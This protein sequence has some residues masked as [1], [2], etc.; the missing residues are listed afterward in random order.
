M[1]HQSHRRESR[2]EKVCMRSQLT[3]LVLASTAVGVEPN[4]V[5]MA[6]VGAVRKIW[7]KTG[8]KKDDVDLCEL[9]EAFSVRAL[10]VCRELGFEMNR[11]NVNGEA[12][13]L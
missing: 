10:G 6:P 13:G 8:W 3:S 5:M 4:W 12:V 7:E 9:N 1:M 11:V 2:A